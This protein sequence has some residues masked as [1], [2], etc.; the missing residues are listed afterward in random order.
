LLLSSI[1]QEQRKKSGGARLARR[2]LAEFLD[3]RAGHEGPA[4]A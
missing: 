1:F 2:H 3:A 4:A